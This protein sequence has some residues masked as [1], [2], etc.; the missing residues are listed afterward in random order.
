MAKSRRRYSRA[1]LAIFIDITS[2][3][4]IA[5]TETLGYYGARI[6]ESCKT[7]NVTLSARWSNTKSRQENFLILHPRHCLDDYTY[8]P[9][10]L[11]KW[12]E[13]SG[14]GAG[15]EFHDF[16]HLDCPLDRFS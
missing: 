1:C 14:G 8:H 2:T 11:H 15:L 9:Q 7:E 5:S 6:A 16:S 10:Y 3:L 12:V 13:R 4:Q